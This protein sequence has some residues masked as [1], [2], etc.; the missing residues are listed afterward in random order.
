VSVY[1]SLLFQSLISSGTHIVA[2]LVVKDIEPLTLTMVRSGLAAVGLLAAVLIR[3]NR[4]SI[5]REDY[6]PMALLSFLAIPAN[7]FLFLTAVKHTTATNASLMYA[8]T[9]AVVLVLSS[10]MGKEKLSVMK[11][12]GVGV[13]FFG[14]LLVVFEH[15]IDL[16]SDY[17][18]GN[19]LLVAAVLSWALYTV[20]GRPMILKYG[21]FTT[22]AVTMIAGTIMYV[23][24]GALHAAEFDYTR[25]TPA[26]WLGLAY[27]SVGTSIFA[28][29]LWYYA[30][31]RIEAS[32]V[33]IFS[34]LQPIMTTLLAFFLL[35]Q[36]ISATFIAGGCIALAGIVLTQYG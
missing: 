14:V 28:Y 31:G 2:K 3:R 21:A 22:S 9:P 10:L 5:A 6:G 13:A 17:T 33:A 8:T 30:L 36:P 23:P 7:Q 25:L 11:S 20:Q 19:L 12:A 15:G 4:P 18:L 29:F 27:L 26:H 34:N 1:I 16:S 32:K 35:G 24:I